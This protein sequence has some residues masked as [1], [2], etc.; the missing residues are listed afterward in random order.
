MGAAIISTGAQ[1]S[2]LSLLSNILFGVAS[3]LGLWLIVSIL[4][5]GRLK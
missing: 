3:F 2:Q 1:T 5:S 4:K